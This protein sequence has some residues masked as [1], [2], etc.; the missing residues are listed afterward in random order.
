MN[1]SELLLHVSDDGPKQTPTTNF[2]D[3]DGEV[4][5]LVG[6]QIQPIIP[7]LHNIVDYNHSVEGGIIDSSNPKFIPNTLKMVSLVSLFIPRIMESVSATA[8]VN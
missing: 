6:L 4:D 3:F 1:A 7:I 2:W 5:A 8:S